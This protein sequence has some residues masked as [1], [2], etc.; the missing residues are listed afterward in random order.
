M[1]DKVI[2]LNPINS[3]TPGR[4]E[5]EWSENLDSFSTLEYNVHPKQN[6]STI[7]WDLFDIPVLLIVIGC[8]SAVVS[9]AAN[10]VLTHGE[11]FRMSFS[12]DLYDY[13]K[14]GL[15]CVM[16]VVSTVLAT[17]I[18]QTVCPQATGGGLPEMKTILGGVV[19]PILLSKKLI[20]AKFV[21]VILSLIGGLSVGKEG[22][23]VHI[24]AAIADQLMRLP[25]FSHVRRQDGKRLEVIACACA[26]GVSSTFGA[27][28]GGV[29]FS[30]EFTA[31]A[32]RV[33]NLPKACLTSVVALVTFLFLGG[34]QQLAKFATGN[35]SGH[36]GSEGEVPADASHAPSA[37]EVLGF[38]LIGVACGLLGAMFVT[39]VQVR[40][41]F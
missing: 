12:G 11:A 33:K 9:F 40:R 34:T 36:S 18:T 13:N 19:K 5:S 22:P 15:Y 30:I 2:N 41:R 28:F 1:K 10:V 31:S 14:L 38:A 32:Y 39:L 37:H 25:I 16:C 21:G 20:V 7:L 3:A 4:L 8:L 17:F 23:F 29:L 27:A 6:I 24:S 35:D 26:S